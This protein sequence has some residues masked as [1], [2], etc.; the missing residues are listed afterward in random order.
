VNIAFKGIHDFKLEIFIKKKAEAIKE[1]LRIIRGFREPQADK[2][3]R[4]I[5]HCL[6]EVLEGCK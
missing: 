1:K 6:H 2:P 5:G 3:R 4:Q